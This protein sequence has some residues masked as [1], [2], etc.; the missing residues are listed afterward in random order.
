MSQSAAPFADACSE[1]PGGN[2][3]A[4]ALL[5]QVASPRDLD[6]LSEGELTALA[7]EIRDLLVTTTAMTGGHLGPNLASSS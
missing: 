3:A 1:G 2:L 7:A 5:D 4:M 6:G